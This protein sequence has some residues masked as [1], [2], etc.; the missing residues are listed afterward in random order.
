MHG[1]ILEINQSKKYAGRTNIKWVVL[2]IHE[3]ENQWNKNGITWKEEYIS[4]NIDSA[5]GMPVAAQF[6]DMW[7]KDEPYGHGLSEVKD[8]EPYFE[9]SEVVGSTERAYIDTIDINGENR[10]VMIAEG[11]LYHQ[12]Y[13]KFVKWLKSELYDGNN[14]DT[15]IEICAQDGNKEIIY[16]S[17]WKERG[18]IPM[19]F[20]FSGSAILGVAPADNS[21]ILLE[22][23]QKKGDGEVSET[24]KDLEKKLIEINELK[25]DLRDKE[26]E[27]DNTSK[28]LNAK[29][30]E[31]NTLVEN[32]KEIEAELNSFKAENEKMKEELNELRAFKKEVEGEKLKAELNSKLENYT[33]DETKVAE[34]EINEFKEDP[35]QEKMSKIIS[36]INSA[37]A[38]ELV[39]K[40]KKNK[41]TEVNN[42]KSS[43]IFGDIYETNSDDLPSIDELL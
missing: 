33:E 38:Q 28:E 12:R 13:P 15:S 11:Y 17:G 9:E 29:T 7:D 23:N 3:L 10:R 41:S 8:G 20:D 4:A 36:E 14:P 16:E 27:L 39:E 42:D 19:R 6:L 40:R 22:L 2:E 25:D 30:E 34:S 37:I 18:R 43:D 5:K 21:A 1:R 26:V 35:S 24:N 32:H 31:V